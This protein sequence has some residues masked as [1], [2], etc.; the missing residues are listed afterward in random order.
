[1]REKTVFFIS[2]HGFEKK[3]NVWKIKGKVQHS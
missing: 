2:S 1:V 3:E